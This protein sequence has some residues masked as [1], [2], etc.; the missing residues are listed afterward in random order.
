VPHNNRGVAIGCLS[1]LVEPS[2]APLVRPPPMILIG[3][4]LLLFAMVNGENIMK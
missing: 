1:R 2:S 4:P 3:D